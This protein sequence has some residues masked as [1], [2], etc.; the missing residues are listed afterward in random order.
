MIL[1]DTPT[2]IPSEPEQEAIEKEADSL[3]DAFV[4][5]FFGGFLALALIFIKALLSYMP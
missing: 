5:I 4:S 3:M 2:K 1:D